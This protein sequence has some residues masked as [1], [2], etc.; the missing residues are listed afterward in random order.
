MTTT[1]TLDPERTAQLR[2]FLTVEAAAD[3][4]AAR[5]RP[6]RRIAVGAAATTTLAAALLVGTT[7]VD[8][9]TGSGPRAE[10]LAIE[11]TADGWTTIRIADIDADPDAVLAE[12]RAAGFEARHE[13]LVVQRSG[14]NGEQV[15][16]GSSERPGTA[17]FGVAGTGE[18]GQQGLAGLTVEFP[19]GEAPLLSSPPPGGGQPTIDDGAG[20]RIDLSGTVSIRSGTK[21]TVVVMTER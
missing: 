3:A 14:P 17:S 15:T 2:T 13:P 19:E 20:V 5:R 10:A 11:R 8:G 1:P 12:L 21:V 7:L 4:V 16:I 6:V 18:P 9:S